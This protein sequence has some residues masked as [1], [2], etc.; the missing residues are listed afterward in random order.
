MGGIFGRG[1]GCNNL[2]IITTVLFCALRLCYR[3]SNIVSI[4]GNVKRV[5]NVRVPPGFGHPFF[6]GSVGRF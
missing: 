3:F 1:R 5:V 6:T 2:I 4:M